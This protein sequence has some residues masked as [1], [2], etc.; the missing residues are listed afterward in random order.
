MKFER[1]DS[2]KGDYGR[3]SELEQGLFKAAALSFG[4]ACDAFRLDGHPFP[5]GLRVK[6]VK[7]AS[8]IWEMTWSFTGP[9]GR[10]TWEWINLPT[11]EPAVRWRRVGG[12]EVFGAP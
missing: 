7:G 4:A 3:L 11:N 5:K 1:T 6:Q 9:D 10:A 8:G 2:F 12:H